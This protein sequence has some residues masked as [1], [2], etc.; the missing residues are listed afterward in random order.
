VPDDR[1][2]V[3]ESG[4]A[5]RADVERLSPS[6]DA[7]LVGSSLM[8]SDDVAFAARA[9][10]HGPVKICGLTSADDARAAADAGAT[11]AGFVFAADSPR[12]V[13][14]SIRPIVGE[15]AG[16]GVKTVG[17]FR[18]EDSGT[19]AATA[20]DCGLNA[21]QLHDGYVDVAGLRSALPAGCEIW[22]VCGVAEAAEPQRPGTDRTLFDT[23]LNGRSGGTG[24]A[25][26]WTLVADRPDL[27]T[28]FLAGGIG[29]SNARAAQQ[30][31]AFGID[32]SSAVESAPGRKDPEKIAALFDALRPQCRKTV[33]CA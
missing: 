10:V 25:F 17:V 14:D 27:P 5:A 15:A 26:D 30:V 1:L 13:A 12:R 7:F 32:L 20:N 2:L 9:L 4:I 18:E 3:S 23:R 16:R 8:A 31:G 33:E 6:V 11:H 24:K 22:S 29:S 19:V 28:S 21:V